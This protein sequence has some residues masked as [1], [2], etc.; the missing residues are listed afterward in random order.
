MT[1][2]E[3]GD[4]IY[5][6]ISTTIPPNFLCQTT[7]TTGVDVQ[8]SAVV[9]VQTYIYIYVATGHFPHGHFPLACPLYVCMYAIYAM[10]INVCMFAMYINIFV[11]VSI[12]QI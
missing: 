10:Y 8:I 3:G 1:V 2:T 12:Y 6:E 11:I 4:P 5:V 7:A 9:E